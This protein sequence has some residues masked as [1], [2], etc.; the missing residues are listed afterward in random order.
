M[1]LTAFA[2]AFVVVCVAIAALNSLLGARHS[3]GAIF[4]S[5]RRRRATGVAR[6]QQNGDSSQRNAL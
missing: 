4:H 1:K 5:C 6:P 2:G 3:S